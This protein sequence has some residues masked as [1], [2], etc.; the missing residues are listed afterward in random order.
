MPSEGEIDALMGNYAKEGTNGPL[1]ALRRST[2]ALSEVVWMMWTQRTRE[3]GTRGGY[4]T[5]SDW[6]RE[7]ER[8]RRRHAAW[9][10][11]HGARPA[12]VA[13]EFGVSAD[14]ARNWG[15]TYA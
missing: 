15:R 12:A 13:E 7:E 1:R 5:R 11:R 2:E 6:E 4:R 3:E 14:T 9:L 8:E 10:V